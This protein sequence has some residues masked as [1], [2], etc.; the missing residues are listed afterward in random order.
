MNIKQIELEIINC[1]KSNIEESG[2]DIPSITGSTQVFTG[3]SGFDSLRAIEV[4]VDLEEVFGCE[5]PPEK[6]FIKKPPG[7]DNVTDLAKA[8]HKIAGQEGG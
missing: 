7:T 5:L 2:E 8:V 1:I 3:I 6:V 4:L